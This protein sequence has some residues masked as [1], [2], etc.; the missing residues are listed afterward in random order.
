M[1]AKLN[2][3]IAITS[4]KKSQAAKAINE[5][6]HVI[7]KPAMFEGINRT[8]QPTDEEGET[9]PPE[10]KSIQYSVKNAIES[11]RSAWTSLFDTSAMQ[12]YA[13]CEARA[14]IVVDDQVVAENVPVTYLL[15]LEKQLI[16]VQ[17]LISKLPTLDPA[18]T[19]H[20]DPTT[21]C[22]AS[23]QHTTNKSKKVM[24]NHVLAAA[25]DKHPAQVQTYTEDV[26]VGEWT[27]T[28]FS[29]AMQAQEQNLYLARVSKLIDAVKFAREQANNLEVTKV[30][31]ATPVFDYIFGT[32]K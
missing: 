27:A 16:D 25:T 7:Q 32:A 5:I 17:T 24:R 23:E 29:G 2:Q 6:Y 19:W 28:K 14:N 9:C 10:K 22:Y 26:K 30:S 12:D 8:Y 13:N 18:E 1:A 3:I 4:G 11:A 20:Y 21:D 15:F 31:V